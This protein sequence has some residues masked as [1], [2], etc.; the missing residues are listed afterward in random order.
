M[1]ANG[2]AK[3]TAYEQDL[4]RNDLPVVIPGDTVRVHNMIVERKV[5]QKSLKIERIAARGKDKTKGSGPQRLQVFEGTVIALNG[6]GIRKSVTVRKISNGVGVEKVFLLN[7]MRVEKIEVVRH[8]K[9]CR[10][11]IYFL[12]KRVGKGIRLREVR[13]YTE[14]AAA[15]LAAKNAAN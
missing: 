5:T 7:S 3:V 13:K 4:V 14:K 2:Q 11:K 10:A 8:G 6:D 15:K 9:V 1:S 12:R